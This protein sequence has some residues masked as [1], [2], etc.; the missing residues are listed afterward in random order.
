[1]KISNLT[2]KCIQ[3][4]RDW[5]KNNGPGCN[6]VIGISGGKDSTVTAM[7]CV[8]ALGKDRVIGVLMPNGD[9]KDIEDSYKVVKTLGIRSFIHNIEDSVSSILNEMESDNMVISQQTVINLPPRIRMATLYAYSQSLNGRVA[10]T[11]NFSETM[12]G[13]ESKFGDSAGDFSPLGKL[14]VSDV[15]EIGKYIA[16][17]HYPELINL[18][19]K[20]PMDGL[21]THEDGTY[22]TDEDILGVSYIAIEAHLTGV[23]YNDRVEHL[24][25][26]SEFKRKP[27]PTFNPYETL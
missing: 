8:E 14:F 23:I 20:T 2:L 5:F 18:V 11:S 12:C 21:N 4:I 1:M 10:N 9:Q 26:S 25:K 16:E 6:A 24:I 15:C 3:W 7:L 17:F 13:F 22:V 27:I 19:F